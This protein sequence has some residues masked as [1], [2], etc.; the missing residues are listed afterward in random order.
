MNEY[1]KLRRY[2]LTIVPR[3]GRAFYNAAVSYH[4]IYILAAV[5]VIAIGA[6]LFLLVGYLGL[7]GKMAGVQKMGSSDSQVAVLLENAEALESDLAQIREVSRRIQDKTGIS[8]EPGYIDYTRESAADAFPS[9]SASPDVDKL[10][11][12]LETLRAEIE[13][14]KQTVL[15]AESRIGAL[16]KRYSSIPS[17]N[18]IRDGE[19]NS[20]FGYR[21]HPISG[22]LEFHEGID[23][24]AKPSTPI[25]ATADGTVVFS[26]W[27]HGYGMSVGI[28]HGN[29]F[30]TL[31]AH[32]SRNLVFENER[33]KKGQII[34]FTGSTG[35]TTGP[36]LHY[37][38]HF[39]NRLLNPTRF[40]ALNF[41]DL[42]RF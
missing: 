28:D 12:R 17:I 21:T 14:R 34:A 29:G 40:L 41:K 24:E 36:H 13:A 5:I 27:R 35:S 15:A 7:K 30:S 6:N 18:P 1:E 19:V 42:D 33:V 23:I 3:A 31:Y 38:V 25:Y 11:R 9:R 37:E 26:E 2:N 4:L 22:G 8:V 16:S 20:G 39:Q 32:N 10:S